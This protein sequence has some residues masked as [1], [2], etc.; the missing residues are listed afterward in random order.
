MQYY[1]KEKKSYIKPRDEFDVK[2][3][4]GKKLI[5]AGVVEQV[6]TIKER[7]LSGK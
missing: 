1:D 3:D 4:R 2:D 5:T 6:E 7:K